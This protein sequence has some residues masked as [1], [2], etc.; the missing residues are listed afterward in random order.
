MSTMELGFRWSEHMKPLAKTESCQNPHILY[1][2]SGRF[3]VNMDDGTE[4]EYSTGDIA[5]MPPGH[6]MCTTGDKPAV[7]L[8]ILY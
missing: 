1:V 8:E 4:E 2:I 3:Q 6:D 7:V 5:V